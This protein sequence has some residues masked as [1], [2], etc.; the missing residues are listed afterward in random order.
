MFSKTMILPALVLSSWG[1]GPREQCIVLTGARI[2][3]SGIFGRGS[4]AVNAIASGRIVQIALNAKYRV[5][6]Y[7]S[8]SND[9]ADPEIDLL[10]VR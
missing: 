8:V 9:P 4:S 5:I 1:I 2:S 10:D 7:N 3:I 6:Y